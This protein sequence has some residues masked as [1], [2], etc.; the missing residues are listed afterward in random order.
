MNWQTVILV[1]ALVVVMVSAESFAQTAERPDSVL[2]S[3]QKGFRLQ[4]RSIQCDGVYLFVASGIA[5]S[6]D[7]DLFQ[8]VPGPGASLGVR[9][10]AE[11]YHAVGSRGQTT[12]PTYIDYNLLLR[13]TVDTQLLRCDLYAGY[14]YHTSQNAHS[15]EGLFKCGI[16]LKYM[17]IPKIAGVLIKLSGG[18]NYG[19]IGAG[20]TVG[21]SR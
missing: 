6:I 1:P 9:A 14:T 5:G 20:F 10:G 15:P 16:D 12:G 11:T 19:I 7:V 8:H 2:A 3:S 17:L 4:F 13:S 18:R 21:I